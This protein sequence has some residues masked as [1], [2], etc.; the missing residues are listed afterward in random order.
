MTVQAV[1]LH[2]PAHLY[3]QLAEAADAA[4]QPLEQVALQSIRVGLPPSLERVPEQFR[5]DLRTLHGLSDELLW[6]VARS[7]LENDKVTLYETLL[8]KNQ[9]GVL[10]EADQTRLDTLR[11]EADLLMLRRSYAYALLKWRGHRIPTLAELQVP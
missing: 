6:R 5:A 11:R 3:Q 2:V 10:S 9:R 1:H 4:Q 7:E 8:E